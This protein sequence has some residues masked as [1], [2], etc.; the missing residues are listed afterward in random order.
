MRKAAA[1][2]MALLTAVPAFAGPVCAA[3][4]GGDTAARAS[5]CCEAREIPG[6]GNAS[7]TASSCCASGA[8]RADLRDL[9]SALSSAPA[10]SSSTG[11]QPVVV[12]AFL[13]AAI[14]TPVAP[15]AIAR[16]TG[17]PGATGPPIYLRSS[18]LLL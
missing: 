1:F 3:T 15:P 14:V 16:D 18:S 10:A 12:S 2:L 8:A 11:R 5:C 13:A 9:D 6:D 7:Y 17:G 4:C